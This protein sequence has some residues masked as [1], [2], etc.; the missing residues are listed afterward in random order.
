M[1]SPKALLTSFLILSTAMYSSCSSLNIGGPPRKFDEVEFLKDTQPIQIL[2]IMGEEG[3]LKY[4][5]ESNQIKY[6]RGDMV[7]KL[8]SGYVVVEHRNRVYA[9]PQ[10]RVVFIGEKE[11]D[12]N[13]N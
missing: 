12:K 5:D 10:E 4:V 1:I 11:P 7:V 2:E 13:G 8:Y 9:I 6:F 3:I